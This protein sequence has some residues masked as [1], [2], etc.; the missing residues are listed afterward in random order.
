MQSR[1]AHPSPLCIVTGRPLCRAAVA[2][3]L[4]ACMSGLAA[5][6][7]IRPVEWARPVI[8][9]RLGNF[10]QVSG[11]LFRS[12]QPDQ[13]DLPD[14]QA[15]GIRSVL[16]LREFHSDADE[17][18]SGGLKLYRVPMNAGKINDGV[19]LQALSVLATAPRP[20]LIHCWHGSDRTGAVVALYRMV[21]Q[22]WPKEQAI[23]EFVNGGYGYHRRSFP[24]IESY[25]ETVDVERL[26]RAIP[27]R[28]ESEQN[29]MRQ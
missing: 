18:K 3:L 21:F 28:P 12:R 8:G 6:P 9:A 23:D 16:N 2:Y 10:Y 20:L 4:L 25:L 14:L 26:K 15:L 17:A 5:S 27:A 11:D 1:T 22:A 19:V 29:E 13:R 7:R 24:E